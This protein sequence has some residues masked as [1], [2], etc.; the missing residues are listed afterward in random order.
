[1]CFKACI[2]FFTWIL[3]INGGTKM[4]ENCFYCDRYTEIFIE[5]VEN[6]PTCKTCLDDLYIDQEVQKVREL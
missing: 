4:K 2:I 5:I 6:E 1:M 3:I